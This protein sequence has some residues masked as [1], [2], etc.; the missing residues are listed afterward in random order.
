[1]LSNE[2][3][4]LFERVQQQL[5]LLEMENARLKKKVF[6]LEQPSPREAQLAEELR[7]AHLNIQH[8]KGS[9]Q[10]AEIARLNLEL[11]NLQGS[12][13]VVLEDRHRFK[14]R[15][16]TLESQLDAIRT[17]LEPEDDEA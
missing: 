1:M 7:L 10:S 9:S 16:A 6:D 14:D 3:S 13:A 8:L 4:D 5:Q 15:C 17:V 12:F 2:L 11:L